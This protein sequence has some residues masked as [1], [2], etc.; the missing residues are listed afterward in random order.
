[1]RT[2]VARSKWSAAFECLVALA[3]TAAAAPQALPNPY[4]NVDGWAKLPNGRVIGAVGDVDID[5]DGQHVW[6]VIRCDA[7]ADKFGYECLD[8][9]LDAVVRFDASGNADR[10]FGGGEFRWWLITTAGLLCA[11]GGAPVNSR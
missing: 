8:S 6:A 2:S 3:F 11:N 10:S 5:P 1:M 9:R 4:R 7:G